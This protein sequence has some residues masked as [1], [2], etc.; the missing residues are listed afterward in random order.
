MVQGL[1]LAQYFLNMLPFTPFEMTKYILCHYMLEVCN[2]PFDF[3][4]T[5]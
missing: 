4:F 5:E 1:A 3:D 2:L